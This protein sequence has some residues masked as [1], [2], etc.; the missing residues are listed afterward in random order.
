MSEFLK[1]LTHAI[2]SDSTISKKYVEENYSDE[3]NELDEFTLD[4]LRKE[5]FDE[6]KKWLESI[7]KLRDTIIAHSTGIRNSIDTLLKEI[8]TESLV[9][10]FRNLNEIGEFDSNQILIYSKILSSLNKQI[11]EVDHWNFD[12]P[13]DYAAELISYYGLVNPKDI[14]VEGIIGDLGIYVDSTEMND[15]EGRMISNGNDAVISVNSNVVENG[16]KRF[17]QAHELGHYLMHKND[18]PW[19]VCT[20][21]DF[22]DWNNRVRVER[23]ANKFAAELLMPESLFENSFEDR[24]SLNEVIRVKD[25]FDTTITATV[26]KYI[27]VGKTP[28]AFIF[29]RPGRDPWFEFS[30]DFPYQHLD[31][32]EAPQKTLSSIALNFEERIESD[33][34]N[35]CSAKQWFPYNIEGYPKEN[36]YEQC[37]QMPRY[38]AVMT[39]LWAD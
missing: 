17:I 2:S 36:L 4:I 1:N 3:L 16:K 28:I 10:S 33:Q 37:V 30:K 39:L 9:T 12:K 35:S 19:F 13:V 32:K 25:L 8:S 18:K 26:R 11:H 7:H 24:F 23:E 27:E 31:L 14:D 38:D 20:K 21:K 15:A 34:I 22:N 6:A 5:K 29:F